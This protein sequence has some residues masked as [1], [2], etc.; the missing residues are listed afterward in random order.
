MAEGSNDNAGKLRDAIVALLA[1]DLGT[2]A[3]AN[4]D[5]FLDGIFTFKVDRP[6]DSNVYTLTNAIDT[7]NTN[8]ASVASTHTLIPSTTCVLKA[9]Q[10][11]VTVASNVTRANTNYATFALVYNDGAG[12]AD[13]TIASNTTEAAGATN[14]IGALTAGIPASATINTSAD[15]IPVGKCI[16]VKVTKT[17]TGFALPQLTM[18]AKFKPSR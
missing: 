17:G 1:P 8:A 5:T 4:V 3:V 18:T 12:G 16:Q 6:V 10:F 11:K 9:N 14:T 7:P 13:T 15:T 2:N